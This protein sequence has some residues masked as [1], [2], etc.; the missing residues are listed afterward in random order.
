M[1]SKSCKE[2]LTF[3]SRTVF[4]MC[5]HRVNAVLNPTGHIR[6]RP[7]LFEPY[8]TVLDKSVSRRVGK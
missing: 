3:K 7:A 4:K 8:S 2:F 1:A 6:E 5:R